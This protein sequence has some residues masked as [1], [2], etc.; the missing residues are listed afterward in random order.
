MAGHSSSLELIYNEINTNRKSLV[1]E[2]EF[3]AFSNSDTKNFLYI[4]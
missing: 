4:S 2:N 1:V 3:F